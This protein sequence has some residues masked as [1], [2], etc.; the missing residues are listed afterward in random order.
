MTRRG[1]FAPSP[2]SLLHL[3]NARTAL[4]AWLQVRAAGGQFLLR[5]EDLDPDRSLS[6]Y[7]AAYLGDLHWLGLDWDEG[8]DVGGPR[9]PY[10]QSR[11]HD[12]YAAAIDRLDAAGLVY[13]CYCTRAELRAAPGAPHGLQPVYPGT[14]R[15]LTPA[16]RAEQ[17]AAGRQPALR[18]RVDET[19]GFEDLVCGPQEADL[20][21][22]CGDFAVRRGDGAFAYQLAVA[23]DDAD[24][25]ITHVLRGADLLDSTFRQLFLLRRLGRPAPLYA[26]VPLVIDP[27][28]RRLSKRD[29]DLTLAALRGAGVPPE[30]LVGYLAWLSGL[31]PKGIACRP[32]ELIAGFD[33]RRVPREPAVVHPGDIAALCGRNG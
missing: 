26:H 13:P 11:R 20:A 14:C 29:G 28:G 10:H 5:D 18:V 7:V 12:R 22:D 1:R 19:F 25:E 32:A 8:P 24:M 23:L 6:Q 16:Q 27:T 9:A 21:R 31:V 4:L 30:R 15:N 3:G 17:A 2:T 33:L